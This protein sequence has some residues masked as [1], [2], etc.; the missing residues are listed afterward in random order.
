MKATVMCGQHERP[1]LLDALTIEIR[2][3]TL[4]AADAQVRGHQIDVVVDR[5]R[6]PDVEGD[7]RCVC[8]RDDL[9]I[10]HARQPQFLAEERE[11]GE[12]VGH[13]IRCPGREVRADGALAAR[14]R[15]IGKKRRFPDAPQARIEH[16][17]VVVATRD[18]AH[19]ADER[20]VST[21]REL[22]ES[23]HGAP[24]RRFQGPRRAQWVDLSVAHGV[25]DWSCRARGRGVDE[26]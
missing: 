13:R 12:L 26:V 15:S 11:V 22:S 18:T 3:D 25:R 24:S 9:R 16:A 23:E 17:D 14:D 21:P 1:V 5:L 6:E 19:R 2:D 10:R 8:S 7:V 4:R 20:G